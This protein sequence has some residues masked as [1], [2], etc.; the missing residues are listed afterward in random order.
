MGKYAEACVTSEIRG[1]V[2]SIV[3]Y[4]D[5]EFCPNSWSAEDL[6]VNMYVLI[7]EGKPGCS[8]IL[9]RVC[10]NVCAGDILKRMINEA[11]KRVY[12]HS[13]Y[14]DIIKMIM[15][16]CEIEVYN[17]YTNYGFH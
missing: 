17:K 2:E 10:E 15:E 8:D 12:R 11:L 4:G 3:E 6:V 5:I 7:V 9:E 1:I 14:C 16:V 13:E